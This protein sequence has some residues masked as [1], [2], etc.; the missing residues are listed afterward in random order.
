M[1]FQQK[2]TKKNSKS[3]KKIPLNS[4]K[5]IFEEIGVEDVS[6]NTRCRILRTMG[7]VVKAKARPP[8]SKK[9]KLVTLNEKKLSLYFLSLD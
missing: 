8:L 5:A 3:R 2:K 4:S 6:R 1:C 9:H 7:K